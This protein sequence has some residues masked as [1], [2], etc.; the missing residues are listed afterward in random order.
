LPVYTHHQV[1]DIDAVILN[2]PYLAA[3][4]TSL[5]ESVLLGMLMKFRL[6]KDMDGK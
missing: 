5:V 4:D 2:S 6:S 3:L 1:Q